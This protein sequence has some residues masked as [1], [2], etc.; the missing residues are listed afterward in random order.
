MSKLSWD[1]AGERLY[2][3]GVD[4]GVLYRFSN[5]EFTDG[6]AWNGLTAVNESP[7][8]AEATA[9][10]ANNIKYLNMLSAEQYGAT[11]EA[12][13]FP[14]EFSECD[15]MRGG[16][17]GLAIRQQ[18]RKLFGFCYRTLIGNDTIGT[19][20]GYKI[21]LV[22]N[23]IASPSGR[24]HSTTNDSPEATTMSWEISTTAVTLTS[25]KPTAVMEI[26]TT[27][28]DEDSLRI[29]EQVLY[30]TDDTPPRLP[31]PDEALA[32]IGNIK[33]IMTTEAIDDDDYALNV[34]VISDPE[35]NVWTNVT[36]EE[37]EDGDFNVIFS[38][39]SKDATSLRSVKPVFIPGTK[40]I[41]LQFTQ[42]L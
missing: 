41:S 32:I 31:Y 8:G 5:N 25:G 37:I 29:L 23:C 10:Y 2:E 35:S 24:D 3:T 21:H 22:Y 34:D 11:I 18:R 20:Y 15:G 42:F 40:D 27:K 19:D 9:V 30:G 17:L 1:M 16:I 12:Y 4:R 14:K 26:D 38:T 7:S 33:V 6:V 36:V 28:C 39:G 13:N